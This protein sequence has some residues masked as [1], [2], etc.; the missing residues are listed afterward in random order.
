MPE[1]FASQKSEV[2]LVQASPTGSLE[3]DVEST[4]L[5]NIING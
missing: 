4:G 5:K 2:V 3:F 1:R